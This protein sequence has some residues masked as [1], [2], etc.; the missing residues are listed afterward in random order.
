MRREILESYSNLAFNVVGF[1]S[2]KDLPF[3]MAMQFL[4]VASFT[5]H[6]HKK[7]PI[8]LFDW[9]GIAV[10]LTAITG[11]LMPVMWPYSLAYL[12]VYG[13][14]IM[15]RF[16]V[17]LEVATFAIP[18]I[19]VLFIQKT[20]LDFS[21]IMVVFAFSIWIRSKDKDIKNAKFNDSLAH[22]AWHVFAAIG[23]YLAM[24]L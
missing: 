21:I 8:F 14:F 6:Y 22:S 11:S 1:L 2:F 23:F 18:L 4:G 20:F 19:V 3:C 15:G 7:Q 17:Y 10:A 5:Y 24:Y 16:N 13:Y 12:V 9:F